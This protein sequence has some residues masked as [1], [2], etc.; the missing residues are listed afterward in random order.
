MSTALRTKQSKLGR[1]ENARASRSCV[2]AS[3]ISLQKIGQ[4]L[5]FL[6]VVAF[7]FIAMLLSQTRMAAH[8][9]ELVGPN[10]QANRHLT[11]LPAWTAKRGTR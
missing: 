11:A 3:D 5:A 6:E 2:A 7:V 4:L 1:K 8:K 9:R 10:D